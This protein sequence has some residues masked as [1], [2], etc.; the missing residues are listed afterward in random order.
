M[1]E[2]VLCLGWYEIRD[3]LFGHNYVK[4]DLKRAFALAVVCDHP[5][6]RWLNDLTVGNEINSVEQLRTA[7]RRKEDATALCFS[8]LSIWPVDKQALQQSADS[9]FAFAQA[10][11]AER[12]RGEECFHYA[13][14]AALD[15]E[16]DGFFWVAECFKNGASCEKNLQLSKEYFMNAAVR[17]HVDA[18]VEYGRTFDW[19][20]PRRW[21]WC[22]KAASR[23]RMGNLLVHLKIDSSCGSAVM[24]AAGEVL[25]DHIDKEKGEIFGSKYYIDEVNQAISM[26]RTHCCFI[27]RNAIH[28]WSLVGLRKN[29]CKDIRI[30]IAKMVWEIREVTNTNYLST[31]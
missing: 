7:C 24:I 26:F 31:N 5:Q 23:G 1:N 3:S 25:K 13:L 27:A 22:A 10:C 6:A 18:M 8:A 20:D 9:G 14:L 15:E 12:K 21:Y 17:G 2:D 30:V 11:M 29:V 4:Q 19:T 16:R 28:M